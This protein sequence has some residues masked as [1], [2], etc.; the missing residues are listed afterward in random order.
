[1]KIKYVLSAIAIAVSMTVFTGCDSD[2]DS[3]SKSNGICQYDGCTKKAD[4]GTGEFCKKHAKYL[5]DVWDA[6]RA[7]GK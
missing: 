7:A 5:N 1:M 6:E 4:N 3:G 2:N